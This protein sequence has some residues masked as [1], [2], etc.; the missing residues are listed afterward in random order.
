MATH[1]VSEML[2]DDARNY[3]DITWSDEEGDRK[4]RGILA[5]GMSYLDDIAGTP[6]CYS[7]EGKP[8][9]LLLDYVRYV[10]AQALDEFA[11]NYLHELLHLQIGKEVEC[12][13]SE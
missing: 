6:L 9:E 13:D 3:C 11:R 8:R 4:L 2:L 5:R 7:E 10:R 1:K 12:R